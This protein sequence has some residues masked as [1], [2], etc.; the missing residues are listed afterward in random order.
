MTGKLI[1]K[2][3]LFKFFKNTKMLFTLLGLGLLGIILSLGTL[4]TDTDSPLFGPLVISLFFYFLGIMCFIFIYPYMLI[5]TD[6]QNNVMALMIASGVNRT[7]L[8]FS[9]IGATIIISYLVSIIVV[10]IPFGIFL[11]AL[12]HSNQITLDNFLNALSN[13]YTQMDLANLGKV[14]L[15]AF[16]VSII[17]Y[18]ST[19]LFISIASILV[20][21]RWYGILILF[22]YSIFISWVHSFF[23]YLFINNEYTDYSTTIS[24]LQTLNLFNL[25]FYVI[26]SA[27]LTFSAIQL[28]KRQ[29]L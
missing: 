22:G 17:Q 16:F 2:M 28:I 13:L 29:N 8:F 6:Y 4:Y 9:K 21:G 7:K 18:F 12:L 23:Q 15:F 26:L 5:S 10:V 3:E 27:I 20:R 25:V 19:L 14:G 11:T 1:F 24:P